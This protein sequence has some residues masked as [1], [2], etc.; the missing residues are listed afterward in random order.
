MGGITGYL[1]GLAAEDAVARHYRDTGCPIAARRWRS[2]A[3]EI[4]LIARQGATVVFV[5]VK[6]A[7]THA[8]AAWRLGPKQVGRIRA[9]V[10][11]FLEGEPRGGMTDVRFDVALVDTYGRVEILENALAA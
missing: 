8:Q 11:D 5:E 6:R 9:A 2:R 4:D 7:A 1:S 10:S 3:G